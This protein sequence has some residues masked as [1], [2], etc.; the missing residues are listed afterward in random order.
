MADLTQTAADVL[1]S[2]GA[3][4]GNGTAGEAI[5]A[6]Q[7]VYQKSSDGK[8]WLADAVTA[9]ANAQAKGI[10]LND[11]AAG[12]P[13][14]YAKSGGVDVGATLTV[15]TVYVLSATSGGGNIC[16]VA[17]LVADDYVTILGPATAADN[18]ALN[19]DITGVQVPT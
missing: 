1:A 2:A 17:D 5:D 12:Q 6:G 10:A 4:T 18:L 8:L 7:V 13:V 15:G 11:A 16:P 3:G 14:T 19:I 9:A